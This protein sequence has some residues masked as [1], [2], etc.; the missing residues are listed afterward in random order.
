MQGRQN[1]YIATVAHTVLWWTFKD[2][3]HVVA[4]NKA[5][6][7]KDALA[8]AKRKRALVTVKFVRSLNS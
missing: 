3:F 7:L 8:R 2:T 1:E 6:A 5:Q 4:S